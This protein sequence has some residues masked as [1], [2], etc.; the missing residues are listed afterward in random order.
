METVTEL[1]KYFAEFGGFTGGWHTMLESFERYGDAAV[2]IAPKESWISKQFSD[3]CVSI[4][5]GL[6][7]IVLP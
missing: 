7:A 4:G 5:H 1:R 6:V 2:S 3:Y